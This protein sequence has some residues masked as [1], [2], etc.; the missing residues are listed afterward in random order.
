MAATQPRT[1]GSLLEHESGEVVAAS[2]AAARLPHLFARGLAPRSTR[3]SREV[4]SPSF[5]LALF[6]RT[7]SSSLM[8]RLFL[9]RPSTLLHKNHSLP[10]PFRSSSRASISQASSL[11]QARVDLTSSRQHSTHSR[12]NGSTECI[13]CSYRRSLVRYFGGS[14]TTMASSASGSTP[15]AAAVN[16]Q[17][18][19]RL[20]RGIL[21][22][23]ALPRHIAVTALT[24]CSSCSLCRSCATG[25]STTTSVRGCSWCLSSLTRQCRWAATT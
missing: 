19:F 21:C 7:C 10:F 18:E 13:S 25:Q 23:L 6:V 20:H 14:S 17:D 22:V 11:R 2:E 4:C 5:P 12:A 3:L 24:L 8:Q 1:S 15:A 16:P 9:L